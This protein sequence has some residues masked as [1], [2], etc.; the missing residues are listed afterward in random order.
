[1]NEQMM[2]GGAT[3]GVVEPKTT[4]DPPFTGWRGHLDQSKTIWLLSL[5]NNPKNRVNLA[6]VLK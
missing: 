4:N 2:K 5:L 1:M 3:G 6:G